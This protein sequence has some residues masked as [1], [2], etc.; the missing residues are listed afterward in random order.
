MNNVIGRH[1]IA[2]AYNG[3]LMGFSYAKEADMKYTAWVSGE[4]IWTDGTEFYYSHG[5]KYGR[6][7]HL[8]FDKPNGRWLE[9]SFPDSEFEY[10]Y[11]IYVWHD[12]LGNTYYTNTSSY[13]SVLRK[14]NP[15]THRWSSVSFTGLNPNGRYVW[16]DGTHT[17]YSNGT[18]Q[19][20]FN[21]STL[22]WTTKT[23]NLDNIDP[24]RI[25]SDDGHV[26]IY[27]VTSSNTKTYELDIPNGV[28]VESNVGLVTGTIWHDHLGNTYAT[29][30]DTAHGIVYQKAFD[31]A[32]G[33]WVD[34]TWYG[35]TIEDGSHVWND[36]VN[37]YYSYGSKQ[38]S[39]DVNTSTWSKVSYLCPYYGIIPGM[40]FEYNGDAY[41]NGYDYTMSS[42]TR[43]LDTGPISYKLN[44]STMTWE[45]YEWNVYPIR[46]VW[47]HNGKAYG[48][49]IKPTGDRPYYLD[50]QSMEWKPMEW[51]GL[52]Y[53]YEPYFR[54]IW[55]D[56][57]GNVYYSDVHDGSISDQ[58]KLVGTNTWQPV[59]WNISN[60]HGHNVW[61]EGNNVYY[62]LGEDQQ[63]YLNAGT[64]T[65]LP[66]TWHFD[67]GTSYGFGGD[68]IWEYN[69]KMYFAGGSRDLT[70]SVQNST[71][72][73]IVWNG[74]ERFFGYDVWISP[75]N[76]CY[77]LRQNKE[78]IELK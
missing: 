24:Q 4:R 57:N 70:L 8:I 29:F 74:V 17:Y 76:R 33:T 50:E 16:N 26:Y 77:V 73:K 35:L 9:T 36:G 42:S 78:P 12:Y 3:K 15:S 2:L 67:V 64:M 38:Y 49:L 14:F 61:H 7:Q 34:K 72:S 53:S 51:I 43:T 1:S 52:P 28:W 71:W 19:Y 18:S 27:Y 22:T 10:F 37:T 68:F 44:L 20:V 45:A 25:W 66:K 48:T 5:S 13:P 41:F 55:K 54:G 69:G 47:Y 11:T 31:R 32:T 21:A 30:N 6:N 40:I 56:S 60:M 58:Y 65:W 39:L 46:G 23:W 62:S 75:D 63:Y 59:T